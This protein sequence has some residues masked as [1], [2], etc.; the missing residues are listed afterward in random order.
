MFSKLI[1]WLVKKSFSLALLPWV[2]WAFFSGIF[3]YSLFF[4]RANFE[5][6]GTEK[7]LL[8]A[9]SLVL[10]IWAILASLQFGVLRIFGIKLKLEG[11]ELN[12][13]NDNIINGHIRPDVSNQELLQLYN[14]LNQLDKMALKR[15]A[16][17]IIVGVVSLAFVEWLASGQL[18]NL[19]IIFISGLIASSIGFICGVF[20][21]EESISPI[22]KECK[23]LLVSRGKHPKESYFISLKSKLRF[24]TILMVVGLGT[25]LLIIPQ[26]SPTLVIFS[27]TILGITVFLG[28]LV[29]NS[30]YRSFLEIG[31]ST[32]NLAKGKKTIFVSGSLSK[33]I[34]DLFKALDV[35]ANE[36]QKA[37]SE[38][39]ESKIALEIKVR[40][41]TRELQELTRMQEEIIKERTAELQKR[42]EELER[43][44]RL[45]VGRELKMI[46]LKKEVKRLQEEL[47]KYKKWKKE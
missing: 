13:L 35:A 46:E 32:N 4:I 16:K 10:L 2:L 36:L 38:L 30:I 19:P 29:F 42:L 40:A 47:E 21:L 11:K 3:G 6:T 39:E 44:Q 5:A 7:I 18:K 20:I 23:L 28:E 1:N 14:F 31:E 17:Y 37:K 9:F 12:F 8:Y 41:R 24:F 33:E 22:R 34:L 15:Y 45:I 43:F 26:I 27:F 25:I